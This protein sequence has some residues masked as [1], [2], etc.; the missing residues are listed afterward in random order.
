MPL[1]RF[2]L[3]AQ[4][5]RE[6]RYLSVHVLI[7]GRDLIDIVRSVEGTFA[8]AEGHPK[9]A[10]AYAGLQPEEWAN[11]PEQYGDGRAAVLACECLEVGCWPLRAKITVEAATVTWSDFEQP[12]RAW[13][14]E[15]LGPFRFDR[16]EYEQEIARITAAERPERSL[17]D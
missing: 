17:T 13:T 6:G 12:H 4:P 14:Y 15:S 5:V 16:T 8:A 9:L 2:H 11:L 10:G 1:N 7:D 3:Q